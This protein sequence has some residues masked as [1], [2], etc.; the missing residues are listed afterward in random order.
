[1]TRAVRVIIFVRLTRTTVMAS[2]DM[3]A[4]IPGLSRPAAQTTNN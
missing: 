4:R 3:C 2:M 1:M